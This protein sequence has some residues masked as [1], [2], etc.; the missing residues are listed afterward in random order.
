MSKQHFPETLLEAVKYFGDEDTCIQFFA[1]LRWPDGKPE[2]PNCGQRE[3]TSY[4]ST[5]RVWKCLECKKQFSAKVGTIFEDSAV[6]LH[7]WLPAVWMIGGAKNGISSYEL[8]RALGVTQKSAWFMLHRIR[9]AMQCGSFMKFEGTIEVDETYIGGLARN[10][11]HDKRVQ[12]FGHGA[13]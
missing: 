11:H 12:K 8:H 7:K 2:C 4:L 6:P 5:R 13:L 3:R 10:M 9:A 1:N